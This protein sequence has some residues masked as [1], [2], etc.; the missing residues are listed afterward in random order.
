MKRPI[1]NITLSLFLLLLLSACG[2]A[3]SATGNTDT[4]RKEI[5]VGFNPGPYIDQFKLG[6]E[7]QL[8]EK[9]YTIQ[10][11]NF[12][13]GVVTN[14]ALE[15]GEIDVNIFQH[16]IYLESINKQENL[17][18]IGIVQVPTPPMGLYSNVYS[19][20]SEVKN[21]AEVA[22]PS[23][24]VNMARGLKLLCE[25]GWI[26]LKKDVNLITISE[27]DIID[28]PKDIKITPMESAMGPRALEDIELV[29][30]QG[31]FA[32][33]SGL[34]LT[35][36]LALE[37]M[38]SQHINVVVVHEENK[39]KQFAYDLIE[40]YESTFFQE[41]INSEEKFNGYTTPEYFN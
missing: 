30:I 2:S 4:T 16:T 27:K 28:N 34:D 39:E 26:T 11:K 22:M 40:A 38:T 32:I 1:I 33:S 6:I 8:K 20:I 23:D 9:G 13:D 31:N 25:L 14:L 19:N 41:A 36:A 17:N 3:E 29:A 12:T 5:T 10:Y 37:N 7:P 18:L 15:H 24:P 35:E 21:G